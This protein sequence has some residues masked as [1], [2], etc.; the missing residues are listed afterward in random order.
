MK[1]D[2]EHLNSTAAYRAAYT[3]SKPVYL[4]NAE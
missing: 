1:C 2:D 3:Y 4:M